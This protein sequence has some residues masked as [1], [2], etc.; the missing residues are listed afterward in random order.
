MVRYPKK[1]LRVY[2]QIKIER[3]KIQKEKRKSS[4]KQKKLENINCQNIVLL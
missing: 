3:F 2:F 4:A 1:H